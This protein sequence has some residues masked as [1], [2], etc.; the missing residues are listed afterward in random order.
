MF[1]TFVISNVCNDMIYI[2]DESEKRLLW[3]TFKT[4]MSSQT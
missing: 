2:K 1:P 3:I 4:E